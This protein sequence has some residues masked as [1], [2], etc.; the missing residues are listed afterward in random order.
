M[1]IQRTKALVFSACQAL[2]SQRKVERK[3]T[4]VSRG[5]CSWYRSSNGIAAFMRR[6][7]ICVCLVVSSDTTAAWQLLKE[8][9]TS[10]LN[11]PV[12]NFSRVRDKLFMGPWRNTESKL[13]RWHKVITVHST[14]QVKVNLI[15]ACVNIHSTE[16]LGLLGHVKWC[17]AMELLSAVVATRLLGLCLS[18]Y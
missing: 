2:L 4:E 1:R 6:S 17:I 14:V 7:R 8:D 12:V 10:F 15:I 5:N 13:R 18:L 9:V 16:W 11:C 3:L